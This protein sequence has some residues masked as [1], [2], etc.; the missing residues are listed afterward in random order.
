MIKGAGVGYSQGA[1]HYQSFFI[2]S[3]NVIRIL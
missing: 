3:Y 1:S 2:Y